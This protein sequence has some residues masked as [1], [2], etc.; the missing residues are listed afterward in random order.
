MPS[1]RLLLRMRVVFYSQAAPGTRLTNQTQTF[2]SEFG[3]VV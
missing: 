3:Q 1:N 2:L